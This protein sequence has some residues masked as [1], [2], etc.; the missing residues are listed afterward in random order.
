MHWS[1]CGGLC[2]ALAR[3][4]RGRRCSHGGRT[5]DAPPFEDVEAACERLVARVP[6]FAG[7]LGRDALMNTGDAACALA[8]LCP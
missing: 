1:A 2:S 4:R 3:Q 6:C 7:A 5:E 8:G